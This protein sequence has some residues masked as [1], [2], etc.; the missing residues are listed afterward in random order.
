MMIGLHLEIPVPRGSS[1]PPSESSS[2]GLVAV[3]SCDLLEAT[4]GRETLGVSSK[5]SHRDLGHS[6]AKW[7]C[8]Y[9][10][11]QSVGHGSPADSTSSH[12]SGGVT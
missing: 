2:T 6:T 1:A 7:V 11:P 8:F 3:G 5:R 12:S 10:T 4:R 9:L